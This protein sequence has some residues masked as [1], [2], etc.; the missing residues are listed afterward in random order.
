[1]FCGKCGAK[2]SDNSSF[3]GKCGARLE[4]I[5]ATANNL[6]GQVTSNIPGASTGR[7]V[8]KSNKMMVAV[9]LIVA[10]AVVAFFVFRSTGSALIGT[11]EERSFDTGFR[12][13][14]YDPGEGDRF[15][16]GKNGVIIDSDYFFGYEFAYIGA[17]DVTSWSVEGNTLILHTQYGGVE[18]VPYKLSGKTLTLYLSDERSAVM[19]KVK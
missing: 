10:V 3:C 8:Q 9:L 1:M 5:I 15:T 19:Y 7:K 14:T 18:Y 12:T 17:V 11:W 6:S 16:L 13:Y 2:N 4:P